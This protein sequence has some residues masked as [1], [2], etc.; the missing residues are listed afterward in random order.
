MKLT[1]A[2]QITILRILLIWPF[3]ICMLNSNTDDTG[4]V[5]RYSAL[6]IFIFM[7]IS[8]IIDGY[9][10]RVKKQVTRLGAFLDPM[11][12]KLL[13]TCACVLMASEK[14]AVEGFQMP[15]AIVVL[16]IGKDLLLLL[17]FVVVYFVT[18]EVHIKPL[19]LG[20]ITSCLQSAMVVATL[21]APEVAPKVAGWGVFVR[22][23]W[24]SVAGLAVVLTIMY[25]RNGISDVEAY[26]ENHAEQAKDDSP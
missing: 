16:V 6:G 4:W 5:M 18:S 26:E 8:D 7:C 22:V 13:I 17:G 25:I 10:A 21:I 19:F 15:S 9:V 1:W 12:D 23:L 14:T 11:A 24:Y 3:I 2:N 20:K